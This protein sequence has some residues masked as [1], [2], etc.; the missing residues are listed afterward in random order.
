MIKRFY[1][2][3][4]L[5]LV[6]SSLGFGQTTSKIDLST[7]VGTWKVD[8]RPTPDAAEYFQEFVITKI[9][10]KT[11]SGTFYGTEIKNGKVNTDWET[12]YL[13]FT[14]EDQSGLYSHFARL[15]GKKL[16]GA[17]DSLGRGFLLPWRAE[18]K[19]PVN[20]KPKK[21]GN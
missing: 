14:S 9:D 1:G 3:V 16:L 8:L 6:V 7:L 11:F 15:D 20:G 17:T 13:A 5:M 10:G 19:A 4:V 2:L 12:V 18:K 21:A